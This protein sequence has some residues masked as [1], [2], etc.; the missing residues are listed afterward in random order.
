MGSHLVL[1]R[2]RLRAETSS[3]C[4]LHPP[5]P[6]PVSSK[7]HWPKLKVKIT[8]LDSMTSHITILGPIPL[9]LMRNLN[10]PNPSHSDR[11]IFP[12][13]QCV[14]DQV[15]IWVSGLMSPIRKIILRYPRPLPKITVWPKHSV[16]GPRYLIHSF[17]YNS[18]YALGEIHP[19]VLQIITSSKN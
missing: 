1:L 7:G 5:L 15:V 6:S 19:N 11:M 2:C 8:L 3:G 4:K 14:G 17:R 10:S 16:S 18:H 13:I 9:E 12:H